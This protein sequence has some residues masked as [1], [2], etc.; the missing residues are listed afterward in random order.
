MV[1]RWKRKGNCSCVF[2]LNHT[3]LYT[4]LLQRLPLLLL[5]H[6]LMLSTAETAVSYANKQQLTG[7]CITT[8]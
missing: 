8:E 2:F 5:L 3:I 1:W 6:R 7:T 4:K